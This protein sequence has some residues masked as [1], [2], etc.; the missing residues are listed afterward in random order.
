MH[1]SIRWSLPLA[2]L[3]AVASCSDGPPLQPSS[4]VLAPSHSSGAALDRGNARSQALTVMSRNLYLGADIGV[5]LSAPSAAEIPFRVAAAWQNVVS[6]DFPDRARALADEIAASRPHLIGL[7]EVSMFWLQGALAYDFLEILLAEMR[8]LGLDYH[9]A[10]TVD[11]IDITL[12]MAT[13]VGLAYVRMLDRDV[14]LVRHDVPFTNAEAGNF[15]AKMTVPVAGVM[16]IDIPRGWTS[17]DATIHGRTYRFVNTH[18][19]VGSFAAAQEAQGAELLAMV[20]DA[21]LPV[22]LVG[23]LNSAADGSSTRTYERVIAADFIDVW[24]QANPRDP[25]YTCC[26]DADLTTGGRTLDE[27]IDFVLYREAHLPVKHRI[28]GSVDAAL[29]GATTWTATGLRP[30]DHA[31]VVAWLRLPRTTTAGGP[32]R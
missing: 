20:Q 16:I 4:T 29:V 1:R 13:P 22:I 9:V 30:S 5:V 25:G 28:A 10:A 2:L 24:T 12:P 32:K 7:Q 31:G 3:A 14:T 8:A 21:G 27:R 18:L 23:D 17:V 26:F 6:T 11:N 15:Q 19:E